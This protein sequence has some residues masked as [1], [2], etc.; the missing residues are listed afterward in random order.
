MIRT[1]DK[2]IEFPEVLL[3]FYNL[4]GLL[5]LHSEGIFFKKTVLKKRFCEAV[6]IGAFLVDTKS[7]ARF[8]CH[9]VVLILTSLADIAAIDLLKRVNV[10]KIIIFDAWSP[11]HIF[12]RMFFPIQKIGGYSLKSILFLRRSPILSL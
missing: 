6:S 4:T 8:P 9:R 10:K 1:I 5:I 12:K 3:E 11:F 2:Q 7:S